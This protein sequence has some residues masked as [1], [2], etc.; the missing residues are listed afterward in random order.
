MSILLSAYYPEGIV[1]A[2]DKNAA[3][4]YKTRAGRRKFVG[5]TA[6]KVLSW[7][8]RKAIVRFVGLG[9]LADLTLDQWMWIF[10]RRRP[11][12]KMTEE[13]ATGLAAEAAEGMNEV[14][15]DDATF[16]T[17]LPRHRFGSSLPS[18]WRVLFLLRFSPP[19]VSYRE[20]TV[21]VRL[22]WRSVHFASE[23]GA[24]RSIPQ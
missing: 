6:T 16:V 20:T 9:K 12:P 5:P 3:I 23:T 14:T 21:F 2:A 19:R 11:K 10:I 18:K 1:F 15:V 13:L 22:D 7:P 17:H 24:G 4:H 8:Y